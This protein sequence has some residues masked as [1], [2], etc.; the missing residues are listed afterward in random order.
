MVN[1]MTHYMELLSAFIHRGFDSLHAGT[2]GIAWGN[3]L[4][5]RLF[6]AV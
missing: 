5:S 3:D 4:A 2:D 6:L 1:I